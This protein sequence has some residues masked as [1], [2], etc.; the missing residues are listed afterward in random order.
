MKVSNSIPKEKYLLMHILMN[1]IRRFELTAEELFMKGELPGFLHSYIGEEAV[2]AGV[3]SAINEN[4]YITTTH[5]GHGHV[6]AKGADVSLMMAELFGKVTGYCKGKSG[7]MHIINRQLGILGANGIVGG[8]I[9]IATGAAMSAQVR[10]SKQVAVCFFGDGASDEGSFHESINLASVYDLPVLYVCENN[11]YAESQR[12][13]RHQ[14]IKNV[15]DRASAYNIEGIIADG[16]D[17]MDVY[18][19]ASYAVEKIR[20]G[21]GPILLEALCYRWSGHYIGDP[22]VYRPKDE[23]LEWRKHK[24]P[25]KLYREFLI[26]GKIAKESEL[27]KI[28]E[29]EKIRIAAAVDFARSSEYPNNTIALEDVYSDET[30]NIS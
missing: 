15:A 23:A 13:D 9:P 16:T 3:C 17:V 30:T 10:G 1:R 22:A 21:S 25:I 5:R 20:N 11:M 26:L 29:D 2:A 8:G 24:D 27:D 14:R 19:K 18:K 4:D 12:Q 6:I 28:I 7:S